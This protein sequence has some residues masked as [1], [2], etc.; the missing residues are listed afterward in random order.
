MYIKPNA[1]PF[2]SQQTRQQS[3]TELDEMKAGVDE[4]KEQM[5]E[6]DKAI[7]EITSSMSELEKKKNKVMMDRV[8]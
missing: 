7:T 4:L 8:L 6:A 5:T 2:H 3:S 1:F